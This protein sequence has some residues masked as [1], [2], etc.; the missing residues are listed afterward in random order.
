M[1]CRSLTSVVF[2]GGT[3][4]IKTAAFLHCDALEQVELQ[5]VETIEN[6]AFADCG[7]LSLVELGDDIKTI[8]YRVF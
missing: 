7:N 3:K 8:Y 6:E 1:E 5:G 2:E 4:Y